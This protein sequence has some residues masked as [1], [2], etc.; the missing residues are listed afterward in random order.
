MGQT[1]WAMCFTIILRFMNR[2]LANE[3]S[4]DKRLRGGEE[5]C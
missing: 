5:L 2:I 3:Q 1:I 4:A